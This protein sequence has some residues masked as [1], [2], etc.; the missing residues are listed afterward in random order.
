MFSLRKFFRS[1][2]LVEFLI[3]VCIILIL[4]GFYA[5]YFN[6]VLKTAREAA[7]VNELLNI[8][9]SVEFYRV[10]NRKLPRGLNDLVKKDFTLGGLNAIMPSDKY[11]KFDRL[12]KDG[13]PQ[14]PF[15]RRYLFDPDT[16][17]VGSQTQGYENW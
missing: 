12:D 3:A 10:T 8:R 6:R 13:Y 16:G 17:R 15:Y 4:A 2:T 9:M 11:L 7:L 5:V 14:D 1:L